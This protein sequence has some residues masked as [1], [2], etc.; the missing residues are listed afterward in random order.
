M[1][2]EL[3]RNDETGELAYVGR[4]DAWHR[5][6]VVLPDGIS[7]EEAIRLGGLGFEVVKV[8]AFFPAEVERA[9]R[10]P[11]SSPVRETEYRRAENCFLI[12]RTDRNVALGQV[13]GA[14]EPLQ[15]EKAFE[16]LRPMIERELA[17]VETAGS[18]REGAD[19]WMLVELNREKLAEAIAASVS[20]AVR[21]SSEIELPTYPT[22]E[23]IYGTLDELVPYV[24][25]TNNHAG[26]RKVRVMETPVR[27]VC[28]NTLGIALG[29]SGFR[30]SRGVSI[31]VAHTK[32]VEENVKTST[33]LLFNSIARRYAFVSSWRELFRAQRLSTEE[34]KRLVLETAVPIRHLERKLARGDGSKRT[35]TALDAAEAKR[36]KIRDMW[37]DG[38]G[39]V[40]DRSIWEAYNGLVEVLDH[41]DDFA[42]RVDGSRVR[43]FF[44]GRIGDVKDSTFDKLLTF[45]TGDEETRDAL[46]GRE[47]GISS[48]S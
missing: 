40:G 16:A 27:V 29:E 32:N 6:G 37:T 4:K 22:D 5:E 34:H 21:G 38:T 26:T 30:S 46:V 13:T 39:H 19:V 48:L 45:A 14:Y 1:A 42:P 24:L 12:V 47:T 23:G 35:E 9:G 25:V 33:E 10:F 28:A 43:A 20:A 7:Y 17:T 15:N 11:F 41:D 18:L 44:S 31:E 36:T 2:H 3:D 8:P